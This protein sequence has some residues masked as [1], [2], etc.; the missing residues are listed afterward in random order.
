M[1]NTSHLKWFVDHC[2]GSSGSYQI[3]MRDGWL[4]NRL[5]NC[6]HARDYA[7]E[8]RNYGQDDHPSRGGKRMKESEKTV[9]RGGVL[10]DP[11]WDLWH[12]KR[13]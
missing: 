10:L 8:G 6:E 7:Q 11:Q 9:D 1:V 2:F 5:T 4:L 3:E 13:I 12:G